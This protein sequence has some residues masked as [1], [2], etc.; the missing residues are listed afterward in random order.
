MTKPRTAPM[1]ISM[2]LHRNILFIVE[3]ENA[4]WN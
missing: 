4:V 2:H 1:H 3:A